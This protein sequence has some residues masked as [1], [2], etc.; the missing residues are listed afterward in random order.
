MIAKRQGFDLAR[1]QAL[2]GYLFVLPTSVLYLTF[3]LMPVIITFILSFSYYDPMLG[4]R[5]VG[6]DNF[7]RFFTNPRS[8][9]IF[10]NTLRFAF[11]AVTFNV[12]I[13]LLLAVALNRAMPGWLLYFFRLAFFMPVIIAVAFV[14]IVWSYFFADDLGV[15]NYFLRLS[16]IRPVHWLTDSNNAMMSIII[17]D[18]WKN[19]GFFMV[20]FIAAL[21]GVPKSITDAALM[22]GTPAWRTFFRIIL[23]YISPVVFFAIVYAS[24]GALQVYESIVI[25]TQGGPGDSTR[26]LSILI[27]EEGF[28][29]FQIGYAAAI[30]VVMTVI[31]LIITAIQQLLSRK[32]VQQ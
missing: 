6:F 13:G 32:W 25:L 18:V 30:S 11:F 26:S 24:I 21:Q 14:S 27:V 16:G 23:P 8:L 5:W 15:I 2:T 31:I 7:T 28:G 1:A 10:W 12:S 3:V 17:M 19:T 22:D 4:S 9:R 20:I 29:S